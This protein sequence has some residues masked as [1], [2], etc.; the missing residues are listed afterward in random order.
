[1]PFNWPAKFWDVRHLW[2][3][4]K[5]VHAR[6]AGLEAKFSGCRA[7]PVPGT[8]SASH[9]PARTECALLR[10]RDSSW[11]WQRQALP[12]FPSAPGEDSNKSCPSHFITLLARADS[13]LAEPGP[14]LALPHSFLCTSRATKS[15]RG[16]G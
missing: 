7:S 12:G 6:L 15:L 11:S 2:G 1:M 14:D 5:T 13:R 4:G 9:G 10:A 16:P 3:K 8:L